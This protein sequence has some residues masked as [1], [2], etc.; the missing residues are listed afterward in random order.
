MTVC[1]AHLEWAHAR[2]TSEQAPVSGPEP[3]RVPEPGPPA[4]HQA[5]QVAESFGADAE[6]YDRARPSYPAAM[7]D[8]IA[9][10]SPGRDVLDVGCGTGIAARLFQAAGC[11]VLGVDPDARMAGLA[12]RSGLTSRWRRSRPG[13]APGGSS[14]QSSPGRHGTGWTRSPAPPGPRGYCVPA[15]GWPCSGTRPSCADLGAAFGEVY[16]EVQPGLPFN[17]WARGALDTYLTMGGTAADGMRQSGGFGDPEEWLF[18]WER[19]Y[20]RD[21]WLD[22][23]PTFGGHTQLAPA[24]LAELLAAIGA[25]VDKAGGGFTMHYT[26]VVITATRTA[27]AA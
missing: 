25:A 4:S 17:P 24:K 15:A 23:L 16:R 20:T 18:D 12:R 2:N 21:E 9:N 5:R 6:R 27:L 8:R 1:A 7:V 26:T 19:P 10:A 22:Q 11:R 14:T 3:R 13:T